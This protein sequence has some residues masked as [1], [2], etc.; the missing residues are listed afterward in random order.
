[1][2]MTILS[3]AQLKGNSSWPGKL[4]QLPA[5][6]IRLHTLTSPS[7]TLTQSQA[8]H[9]DSELPFLTRVLP[10]SLWSSVSSHV[11]TSPNGA[12]E[13]IFS[14]LSS[15]SPTPDAE[16]QVINCKRIGW[17][18]ACKVLNSGCFLQCLMKASTPQGLCLW[19]PGT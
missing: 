10:T 8:P 13:T 1:M 16:C 6:H 19:G 14:I 4:S 12:A 17:G 2:L 9:Q 18:P 7:R 15:A 5:Q 3:Q 11:L